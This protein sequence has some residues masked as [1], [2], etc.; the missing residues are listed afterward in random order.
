MEMAGKYPWWREGKASALLARV[1]HADV[2][3]V[4]RTPIMGD[5]HYR[6][7]AGAR[8]EVLEKLRG[9]AI[10]RTFGCTFA[11]AEKQGRA[12][13]YIAHTDNFPEVDEVLAELFG[14]PLALFGA[15]GR[16]GDSTPALIRWD[17]MNR[18]R[19]AA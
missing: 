4:V 14:N 17:A 12:M 8:H 3:P 16:F 18:A 10:D 6:W 9:E 7:S 13:A 19:E 15:P 11:E 2:H 1:T 5:R